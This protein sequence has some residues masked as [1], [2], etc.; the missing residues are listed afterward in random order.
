MGQ[1]LQ[2]LTGSRKVI[3]IVHNLGHWIQYNTVCEIETTQVECALDAAKQ[4]NIL[5]LKPASSAETVFTYY[6]LDDFDV[7]V[8]RMGSGGSI[9]TT[10]LTA[11][12]E[13]QN[14]EKNVNN[15]CSKK[16]ES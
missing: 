5:K 6:W 10:H 9:N 11:F 15:K 7:K 3:H 8:E 1:G 12:Q 2:N 13:D 14:H 16:E 4:S